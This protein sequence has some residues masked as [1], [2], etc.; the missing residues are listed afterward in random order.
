[1]PMHART[2]ASFRFIAFKICSS[3]LEGLDYRDLKKSPFALDL[4]VERARQ[5][6]ASAGSIFTLR[7]QYDACQ[8]EIK[9]KY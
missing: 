6:A 8:A 7:P 4:R 3:E 5:R 9:S 1:M 2:R